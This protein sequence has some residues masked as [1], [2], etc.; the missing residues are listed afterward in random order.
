[1]EKTLEIA[2]QTVEGWLPDDQAYLLYDCALAVPNN[3]TIVELGAWKGRSSV[4]L[5]L[6]CKP[7]T[8]LDASIHKR[9]YSVDTFLGSPSERSGPHHEATLFPDG[10]YQQFLAN[11]DR[12]NLSSLVFPLAMPLEEAV[13]NFGPEVVDMLFI[14][15][16][17]T[18]EATRLAFELWLPK[19]K[20]GGIILFHDY[21]W[22]GV[23]GAINDLGL[24]HKVERNIGVWVK[25]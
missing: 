22:P 7:K 15:C 10:V 14:D 2:L 25:K 20:P 12:F 19:V 5:G 6:A 16:E 17:H 4:V 11:V 21:D 8:A 23:H 3:G 24:N 9:V 1:M 13:N 18:Y